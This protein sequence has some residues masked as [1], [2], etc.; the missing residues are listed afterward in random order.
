MRSIGW[1]LA[2]VVA[3]VWLG[4]ELPPT[5]KDLPLQGGRPD[6]RGLDIG[7]PILAGPSPSPALHPWVVAT[8]QVLLS[9]FGLAAFSAR[10]KPVSG[11]S[12][13]RPGR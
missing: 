9:L 8:E 10:N 3:G 13:S 2:L 5:A 12:D 4:S 11:R 1:L 6:L 7:H